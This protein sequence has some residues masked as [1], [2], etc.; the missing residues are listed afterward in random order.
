M[1]YLPY[2]FFNLVNPLVSVGYTLTGFKIKRI[3][4]AAYPTETPEEGAF[5]NVG[6]QRLEPTKLAED[7]LDQEQEAVAE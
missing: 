2:C 4:P 6:G 3:D 1:T 5:Y 7:V